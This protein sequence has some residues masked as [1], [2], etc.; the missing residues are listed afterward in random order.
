MC[1]P[2]NVVGLYQSV[3]NLMQLPN[4]RVQTVWYG[5]LVPECEQPNVEG[6][7]QSVNSLMWQDN[8]SVNSLMWHAITRVWTT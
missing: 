7:Y 4:T 5:R 6:L 8:T 3:N 2:P 1:E